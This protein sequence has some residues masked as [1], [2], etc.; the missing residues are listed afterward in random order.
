MVARTLLPLLLLLFVPGTV[1]AITIDAD[2]FP[3]GTPISGKF[4]GI[5]L[6]A[7]GF[8]FGAGIYIYSVN[9]QDPSFTGDWLFSASTGTQVF[10]HTGTFDGR[11]IGHVWQDTR[12]LWFRVDFLDEWV[13]S[14]SLDFISNDTG[15]QGVLEAYDSA[16]NLL[17]RYV[18]SS[19]LANQVE[20]MTIVRDSP[21][22]AYV[23]AS[24]WDG[25]T[26]GLDNLRYEVDPFP[27]PEPATALLI[28][29]GLATLASR[30]LGGLAVRRASA[31]ARW[32]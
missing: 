11:P 22:I 29:G 32:A 15:D 6:R 21:S 24:A 4:P 25:N 12:P 9:P 19:L 16:S 23:R 26:G 8:G 14:V 31:S 2:A 1:W 17:D 7:T 27:V 30:R 20:T 18:T 5:L 3:S 28:G 13:S 10:G